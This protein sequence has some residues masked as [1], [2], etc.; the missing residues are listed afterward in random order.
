MT[1][2]IKLAKPAQ[3]ALHGAG[4][5]TLNQLAKHSEEEISSLHGIGQNVVQ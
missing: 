1:L 3:R 4:I 2:P 5:Q